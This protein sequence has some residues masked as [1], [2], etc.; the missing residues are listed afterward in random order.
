MAEKEETSLQKKYD[1]LYEAT[2]LARVA[3]AKI[4][5]NGALNY[6][7]WFD[8]IVIAQ[9]QLAMN[10]TYSPELL[11]KARERLKELKKEF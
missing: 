6:E 9:Q 10:S 4:L 3:I 8:E 5:E 1:E 2:T 11:D 7:L